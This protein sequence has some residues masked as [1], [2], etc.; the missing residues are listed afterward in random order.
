MLVQAFP[1][2]LRVAINRPLDDKINFQT[3]AER[4][5]MPLSQRYKGMMCSVMGD[6]G[7]DAVWYILQTDNLTNTGWTEVDFNSDNLVELIIDNWKP[8]TQYRL[9]QPIVYDGV[10]YRASIAHTSATSF[11]L[12]EIKWDV[13]SG[14]GIIA[15]ST[16]SGEELIYIDSSD[17]S[18]PIISS[19]Q[20]LIN[21]VEIAEGSIKVITKIELEEMIADPNL[22]SANSRYAVLENN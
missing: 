11:A 19:T 3:I 18:N 15:I 1:T 4:N 12:D 14:E 6:T 17:S 5:A 21:A 20:R 2:S 22:M 16:P 10:L 8:S 13:L 9:H 7:Q